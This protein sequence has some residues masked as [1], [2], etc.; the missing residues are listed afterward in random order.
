MTIKVLIAED[1]T[2]VREGIKRI[3]ERSEQITVAAE[4]EDGDQLLVIAVKGNFDITLLD[5]SMPGPGFIET[6]KRL[7]LL[8]APFKILILSMHPEEQYAIRALKAGAD[9]YLTKNL[10]L[11]NCWLQ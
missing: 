2:L 1:Q 6:M 11:K 8:D 5:I 4:V 3:I 10:R 9:G 7:R